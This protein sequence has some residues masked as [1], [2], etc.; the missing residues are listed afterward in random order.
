MFESNNPK[1]RDQILSTRRSTLTGF[2]P[3][4]VGALRWIL[5]G[6]AGFGGTYAVLWLLAQV[7]DG[8]SSP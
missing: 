6:M 4:I 5:A 2:R 1:L 8:M 7:W 3:A